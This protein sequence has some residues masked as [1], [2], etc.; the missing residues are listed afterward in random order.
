M[1]GPTLSSSSPLDTTRQQAITRTTRTILGERA[2][3]RA[4]QASA[5]LGQARQSSITPE[6]AGRAAQLRSSAAMPN[7]LRITNTDLLDT[8]ENRVKQH[9]EQR[10]LE[11]NP[12]TSNWFLNYDNALAA[13]DSVEDIS[14]FEGLASSFARGTDRAADGFWLGSR[15][16][17]QEELSRETRDAMMSLGELVEEERQRRE[18]DQ[19]DVDAAR[20]DRTGRNAGPG[21]VL[22]EDRESDDL[23][24]VRELAARSQ[25]FW[26]YLTSRP[27]GLFRSD[28]RLREIEEAINADLEETL[29]TIAFE[30]AER[31]Q[32]W[33]TAEWRRE[34]EQAIQDN[35][36]N[37]A[38]Q[39]FVNILN[40]AKERPGRFAQ[41]LMEVASE[42]GV[43]IGAGIAVGAVTRS[44]ALAAITMGTGSGVVGQ[45]TFFEELVADY[46]H[47][48]STPEGR[49]AF[50]E[51]PRVVRDLRDKAK[52][53]GIVIGILDAASGGIAGKALVDNPVGDMA[54]QMMVQAL[55]GGSG[56]ALGRVAAGEDVDWNE[57]IIEALAETVT[58]PFEVG[59]MAISGAQRRVR[60]V[61]NEA[62]QRRLFEILSG[63][64]QA[65]QLRQRDRERYADAI[66]T[67]TEDGPA[68]NIHVDPDA[69]A[70]MFQ[71]DGATMSIEEFFDAVPELDY[72][73]YLEARNG[74]SQ[75]VIPTSVYAAQ[76]AGTDLDTMLRPHIKLRP[77]DMSQ[78]E[79][80]TFQA[81]LAQTQADLAQ[82][83]DR[84]E[85]VIGELEGPLAQEMERLRSEIVQAHGIRPQDAERQ[86][87]LLVA[88]ARAGAQRAGMTV[89]EYLRRYTLPTVRNPDTVA[90][91]SEQ[92]VVSP[93]IVLNLLNGDAQEA[94]SVL[95]DLAAIRERL[96]RNGVEQGNVSLEDVRAAIR[97]LIDEGAIAAELPEADAA[98]PGTVDGLPDG[99]EMMQTA[100]LRGGEEDASEW[101]IDTSRS[102]R[103]RDIALALQERQ[104]KLYGKTNR[105]QRGPKTID[106]LAEWMAD[107]LEFEL[108]TPERSAVGWYGPKFQQALDTLGRVWSPLVDDDAAQQSQ[109]PGV[110][111]RADARALATAIFAV[112][113][114]G[115]KV[116]QN[117]DNAI[118][119]LMDLEATGEID[120]R[121]HR[122]AMNDNIVQILQL[123]EE[124]GGVGMEAHLTAEVEMR[125]VNRDIREAGGNAKGGYPADMV[126]PYAA[127]YFGP[128]LA[129]FYANLTGADGYLTMDLWWTR[130]I[131]RYQ[132]DVLPK[133]SG[134]KNAVDS[135]GR[136]IGLH[137]FKHLINRPDLTDNQAL[138]YA[139]EYAA[140]Y[141]RKGF[142]NGTE[143][144]RAANTLYKAAFKMLDEQPG[145]AK[146]RAFFIDIARA[147]REKL[148]DRTGA[149]YSIADIQAMLWYYEKR[150][151]AEMGVRDSGDLSYEEAAVQVANKRETILMDPMDAFRQA[152]DMVPEVQQIRL[153]QEREAAQE[154]ERQA[155]NDRANEFADEFFQT[156]DRGIPE[157]T[158]TDAQGN[159]V[160][161][162]H[163]TNQEFD[164]FDDGMI[165]FTNQ[166][167]FA[168]EHVLTRYGLSGKPRVIEAT[169]AFQNEIVFEAPSGVSPDGHYHR[170]ADQ[171]QEAL[172]S[173]GHDGAIIHNP[174]GEAIVI[175]TRNDQIRQGGRDTSRDD[176]TQGEVLRGDGRKFT[177]FFADVTAGTR[178]QADVDGYVAP[179]NL[180]PEVSEFADKFERFSGNFDRHI[181]GSIPGYRE[182]QQAVAYSISEMMKGQVAAT[183]GAD[184]LRIGASEGSTVKAIVENAGTG[185]RGVAMDPNME[186]MNTF[187]DKPQVPGVEF[188]PTAFGD[189]SEAGNLLWTEDDG[190]EVRVYDP[191]ERRFDVV[192]E[193]M[194]FQFISNTRNAQVASAKKLMKPDGLFYTA[195]KFGGPA[196]QYRANEAKKDEF[197][198]RH[199][200]AEELEAKRQEVL[201]TGG[202]AVEG[203]TDLQV[204]VD[205]METILAKNFK[206]VVQVWDSGNFKGYAASD[207]PDTVQEFLQN[208]APLDSE[209]ANVETP[210]DV[211]S[212]EFFQFDDAEPM[213]SPSDSA[214]LED[215]DPKVLR[216][217]TS[218]QQLETFK[219]PG[220]FVV[221]GARTEFG[222][223]TSEQ[224]VLRTKRLG[225]RLDE[226]QL[227]YRE[228]Q[229]MYQGESDGVSFLVLANEGL[230]QQLGAEWGQESILSSQGLTYTD[231]S[232]RD[233]VPFSG[234]TYGW[235]AARQPFH[236]KFVDGA[237]IDQFALQLD[238]PKPADVTADDGDGTVHYGA[239]LVDG[240]MRLTHFYRE[241][242]GEIDP[243]FAGTGELRGQERNQRGPRKV[244]FGLHVGQKG[245][246]QRE[247]H[248]LG[249]WRH[250]VLIDPREMY[251]W[252]QDPDGINDKIDRSLP[253][254]QQ[255]GQKEELIKA[256]GYK[257][258]FVLGGPTGDAAIMFDAVKPDEVTQDNDARAKRSAPFNAWFLDSAVVNEDGSPQMQF[259]STRTAVDFTSFRP[260]SHFG[261]QKSARMRLQHED[262]FNPAQL[263]L[264][265]TSQN[266]RMLPVYLSIQN[267]LDVGRESDSSGDNWQ[268]TTDMLWQVADVLNAPEIRDA[269]RD[270]PV[271]T[272][273]RNDEFGERE[274]RY[275]AENLESEI[276]LGLTDNWTPEEQERAFQ[277]LRDQAMVVTEIIENYGHD[278]VVYTN[279]VEDAGQ[280]SYIAFRPNQ[281]KSAFNRGSWD[282]DN[283]DLLMQKSFGKGPNGSII[284]P[285]DAN[286][287]VIINLFERANMSTMLHETGHFFLWQL[288]KQ[289]ADGLEFAAEELR[290]VAQWWLNNADSIAEEAGVDVA[291]VEEYLTVG[292]T[293]Q[294]D[295][296]KAVHRA[297]HEQFARG[298]EAY[299]MEGKSPSNALRSIFESFSAWLLSWYKSIKA[300]N[301]NINDDIRGVFD[302]M[303]AVEEEMMTAEDRNFINDQVAETAREMGLDEDSYRRL[304]TL[305]NEA[306]EE[307]KQIA[308]RELLETERR[309]RS[310]E[311]Q[312]RYAEI[313]AEERERINNRPVNRAI[314]W[315]AYGRWLGDERPGDLPLELRLDTEMLV[316]E[317]GREILDQLPRGRRPVYVKDTLLS[318]DDVAEWFGFDSGATMLDAMVK[319]PKANDAIKA[320]TQARAQKELGDPMTDPDSVAQAADDAQHGEKRGQVIVAELRAMNRLG[321]KKKQMTTRAQAKVIA[322]DLI[323]R[324]PVR[325]A[326]QTTRYLAAERKHAED[327]ARALAAG[328]VD[329]AFEFKRKQ[330]IQHQLYIESR[331]AADM[332]QKAENLAGR[333][334]RKGTRE[335]LAPEY[336]GAIDD[337]LETYDFRKITGK[338]EVR[339][340]RLQAYIQGMKAQNRESEL[341]IPDHVL[342]ETRRI[343]YKQLS[344]RRLQGVFDSLKNIEHTAR[345]KQKLRLAQEERAL[346][347]V[348]DEISAS[349][350]EN[351][352]GKPLNRIPTWVDQK[353]EGIEGYLNL[354]RNA[355]TILR[356]IDGWAN[357][358]VMVRYFK[359]DIDNAGTR[360]KE[361]RDKATE[362]ID[363]LFDGTYSRSES[364][365]MAVRRKWDGYD[366]GISKWDIIS[367]AL[368]M[369]NKDNLERLTSRDSRGSLTR[370]EVDA[371]VDNLDKRDWDFVQG[372]WDYLD[373]EFWPLIAER[374]RRM[375]GVSPQKVQATPVQ[376]KFGEYKGGYYPIVYD[377]R[378]SAKVS[379]DQNADLMQSMMAGRFGKAQTRNGHTKERAA[380]GGGRTV[381]LGMHVFFGHVNNVIHDLAFGEAVNNAWT[382]LQD[383][384]V[385]GEFEKNG[386][387]ADHQALELWVQDVAAGPA[388]GTHAL[389]SFARRMKSGFTLSKLAFNMAT[390]AIQVT[391]LTQSQALLGSGYMVK[392]LSTY[393]FSK[394]GRY[395][396][397]T[398]I[399]ERS[400]FMRER[401]ETFQRD[402]YDIY[403]DVRLNP[404]GGAWS[405]IQRFMI[406]AGFFAMQ[407]VQ[408]YAVDVPTWLA[409][410]QKGLDDGMTDSEAAVFA[411]RMVARA[412]ASGLYADRTAVERGTMGVTQRQGEFLRLFT[413]LGSY[414]FAKYNV[415]EEVVGRTFRDVRDPGR[416]SVMAIVKGVTDLVL[417]FALEALLYHAIRGS[418]PGQDEE[419]ERDWGTFIAAETALSV[420]SVF[421]FIRDVSG[422]V[423]GFGGGG[424]YGGISE[425]FG[426]ALAATGDVLTG[427]ATSADVRSANDLVGLM[428]PGYP[429]TATWRLFEGAGGT[430]EEPSALSMIMGR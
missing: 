393:L 252:N 327:A 345:R 420:V 135:K 203:M 162:Y 355:D 74:G 352:I 93:D 411:D 241:Q 340:M 223:A 50:L 97:E 132:G 155:A 158:L 109:V 99:E 325:E 130:S 212:E 213:R 321:G 387:L 287:Q 4:A 129:A 2:Q 167:G 285:K 90:A 237:P 412:Q 343:P 107:E 389:A 312:A 75:Y 342:N 421:P 122:A 269:W 7:D 403:N 280:R 409:A 175:A 275:T 39:G 116:V 226:L 295:V 96:D 240:M 193:Q 317:H 220:W 245:G 358:G 53:Y 76:I 21:G 127:R 170:I 78:A 337:I 282:F 227:P 294:G 91:T 36:G 299:A 322:V 114:N 419:E 381:Q 67:V 215:F 298:F 365:S 349:F 273:T 330:L 33:P 370:A 341:A 89:S 329:R 102:N 386:M 390:V 415:A 197:K 363:A 254:P 405:D 425:T 361:L 117:V 313:E 150:L 359:E 284:L 267:P 34:I 315:L 326:L 216:E 5:V 24:M 79:V 82:N 161:L 30:S 192:V 183:G 8:L 207:N 38:S 256:A 277:A 9:R 16:D 13:S 324:M 147:A 105:N 95:P 44:P 251:P 58:A 59:G 323:Q 103:T 10:L 42:S 35:P 57:V 86:A 302:R 87:G 210:R 417:L 182:M 168:S 180:P 394:R 319:A 139:T 179:I 169:V 217:L 402:A 399:M 310:R 92:P 316:E 270:E 301:V 204:S 190:F 149:F 333:L 296:D 211:G 206:H 305:S 385:K 357:R 230:G 18:A 214:T 201:Q 371:L 290:T 176:V 195:E 353:R 406:N 351:I 262:V 98:T 404:L 314:Q 395:A 11:E 140:A 300:L 81:D 350:A 166:P 63:K 400:T 233:N 261:T 279:T 111:S 156:D 26:R 106:K 243:A 318:A 85:T 173:G 418:L 153:Q 307:G 379:E 178:Q 334:K 151:Y 49:S 136:P 225:E 374:E 37:T 138:N 303:V 242:L 416:S 222:D 131:R 159:P 14:F 61:Q 77:E 304:V 234:I 186:M 31:E 124:M 422:A 224:N 356:K 209:F 221:T 368:N 144:E 51:D 125:E 113:S 260:F 235:D 157:G 152:F 47:D 181:M 408:Y 62:Q 428:V 375:T 335:N 71:E 429:S 248:K 281:V 366:Q 276:T 123:V 258:Y 272:L 331:K 134:M 52:A 271:F 380:G 56:E 414:M 3:A 232:N 249:S 163:G 391:G 20:G 172:E 328:E 80:E 83:T 278:G 137:R 396:L 413:A 88:S 72:Q 119:I 208:L 32:I 362:D 115:T 264:D 347:V 191:G 121:T 373:S 348:R 263:S 188:S 15:L 154:A 238:F 41:Y 133:I 25:G 360:A 266:A 392:G 382:L 46:G 196:A 372:V 228:L 364:R 45:E 346:Q 268:T 148:F 184:M 257:G 423:Q 265:P 22:T 199:F 289:A 142:K 306:R 17:M 104:R 309:M 198:A 311:Y 407:K 244:F 174:E 60:G 427:E 430:G 68:E 246:Y 189:I 202:D 143:A 369:G 308:R 70:E 110:E 64:V 65:S 231:G 332:V 236:S 48:I 376:T 293:G 367:I 160:T 43:T 297:L 187:Y 320:A 218:E 128:K 194:V 288:Q 336:L 383:Q 126:V 200:T 112:S 177:N 165:F 145:S 84:M 354:V 253:V 40:I 378:Y 388:A 344:V 384:Q 27:T 286:E 6:T 55:L 205:E 397:A 255:V 171:V 23:P 250:E 185:A 401:Q 73:E 398:D 120:V 247:S 164:A 141:E 239:R 229:G 69:M 54:A 108:Q 19:A 28:E 410:H 426:R 1:T 219:R 292:S 283:E 118:T 100:T 274:L 146:E 339:R 291:Q 377:G 12:R 338:A 29:G 94:D 259:H 66:K 101:G 424:A